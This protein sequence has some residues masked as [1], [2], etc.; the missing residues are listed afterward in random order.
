M[1]GSR[2]GLLSMP[3]GVVIS[4]THVYRTPY[5]PNG[6]KYY[7]ASQLVNR[8]VLCWPQLV[9]CLAG[10]GGGSCCLFV[11]LHLLACLIAALLVQRAAA[12]IE[13]CPS[14]LPSLCP[15]LPFLLAS[16]CTRSACAC[17]QLPATG[18][19]VNGTAGMHALYDM[20]LMT[21]G[22]L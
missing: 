3:R 20:A 18:T 1:N 19:V 8:V 4:H 22:Q 5:P 7:L 13:C 2:L 9:A 6:N 12:N 14:L 21:H 11:L 16:A 15:F 17:R 10:L